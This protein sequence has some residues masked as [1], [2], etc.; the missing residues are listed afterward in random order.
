MQLN[1]LYMNRKSQST[2]RFLMIVAFK[3]NS[4]VS[5]MLSA[6]MHL[7]LGTSEL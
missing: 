1:E 6:T 5:I 4:T 3:K 7:N 2:I